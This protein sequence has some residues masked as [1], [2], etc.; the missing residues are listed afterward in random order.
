MPEDP[1]SADNPERPE[2]LP[3]KFKDPA[4]LA[5]SYQ[6]AER[7]IT[8]LAQQ[9]AAADETI[10]TFASQF[11]EMQARQNQPQADPTQVNNQWQEMYDNDPFGTMVLLNRQLAQEN[12]E[13]LRQDIQNLSK[14]QQ[15]TVQ[16]TIGANAERTMQD[17][18]SDWDEVKPEVVEE[19]GKNPLFSDESPVWRTLAGTSAA[20]E[21][22]YQNVKSRSQSAD[23]QL[24]SARDMK[25]NAQGLQGSGGRPAAEDDAQAAWDRIKNANVGSYADLMSKAS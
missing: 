15:Q 12:A 22:A 25:L 17:R 23:D 8:E 14:T 20:L 11:E 2:W 21:Q 4:D 3:E 13:A 6:E 7:R 16:E 9:K 1:Q 24:P 18:F 10:Q 5:K 19:L